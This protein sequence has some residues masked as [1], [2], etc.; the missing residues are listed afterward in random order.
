MEPSGVLVLD[1]IT[2]DVNCPMLN[3]LPAGKPGLE[4]CSGLEEARKADIANRLGSICVAQQFTLVPLYGN[5][6]ENP[7]VICSG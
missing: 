6:A 4:L 7:P 3:I 5:H 1:R 2:E